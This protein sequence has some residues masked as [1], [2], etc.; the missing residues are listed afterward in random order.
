MS[1]LLRLSDQALDGSLSTAK[2][3]DLAV[4][5]GKL[6][7]DAVD[8]SK[9]VSTAA[10][11]Y[12]KLSLTG[13][14]LNADLAGS[15]AYSKLSLA[16]SIVNADVSA[17]AAIAES[18]LADHGKEGASSLLVNMR[19]RMKEIMSPFTDSGHTTVAGAGLSVDAALGVS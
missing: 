2:M 7:T 19:R 8:N 6:A 16:N 3:A 10:I 13:A 18:K 17:G 1:T 12:S 5:N 4:T 11:A 9:I 14:I 15:I